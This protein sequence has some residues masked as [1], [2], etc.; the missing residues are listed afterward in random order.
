MLDFIKNQKFKIVLLAK[1][2]VTLF[3]NRR[4]VVRDKFI[5]H[6]DYNYLKQMTPDILTQ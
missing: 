2:F 5:F 4:F 1:F 6:I 3:F